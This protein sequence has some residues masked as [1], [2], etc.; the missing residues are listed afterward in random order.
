[1]F[2]NII[3]ICIL[4]FA[5]VFLYVVAKTDALMID[6]QAVLRLILGVLMV[7]IH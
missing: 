5:L 7:Q 6:M 3:G 1:M 2:R 4:H